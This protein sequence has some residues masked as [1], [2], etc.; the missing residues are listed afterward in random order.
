MNL[1]SILHPSLAAL[2]LR[3]VLGG[4]LA[5]HG[6]PKLTKGEKQTM[7][8][9]AS[10]GMPKSLGPL[11]GILELVGGVFYV[12]GFLTP[13]VSILFALEFAGVIS[14]GKKM[15][16]KSLGDYEKD[17][18]FLGGALTML[19]LGAGALSL[20]SLLGI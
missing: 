3:L 11:I 6:Y 9:M 1:D 20:D 7:D 8:W 4:L 13:F 2:I 5:S 12:I 16:K 10:M 14:Q 15:G 18:L 19:F 17:L